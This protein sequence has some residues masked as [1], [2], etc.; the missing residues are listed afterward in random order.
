MAHVSL[1]GGDREVMLRVTAALLPHGHTVDWRADDPLVEVQLLISEAELEEYN[2]IMATALAVAAPRTDMR[3]TTRY[4]R[5]VG[6]THATS[7]LEVEWLWADYNALEVKY[8]S[9]GS[10]LYD[11]YVHVPVVATEV[12]DY[13]FAV[14]NGMKSMYADREVLWTGKSMAVGD[15]VD[16]DRTVYRCDDNGWTE[17]EGGWTWK[18]VSREEEW[19]KYYGPYGKECPF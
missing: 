4:V 10:V 14:F 12:A 13:V 16:I 18:A 7:E 2:D 3:E 19:S 17:L 8:H 9:N 1:S 6:G 5:V 11:G 15:V